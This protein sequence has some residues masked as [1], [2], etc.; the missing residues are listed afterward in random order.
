MQCVLNYLLLRNKCEF[1]FGLSV[2]DQKPCVGFRVATFQSHS[3]HGGSGA[4]TDG[5]GE[6]SMMRA[7]IGSVAD[8]P[9]V[10]NAMKC[11]AL[12]FNE[13]LSTTPLQCYNMR[14]H[15]GVWRN[16]TLRYSRRTKQMALMLCVQLEGV[17]DAIWQAELN[18]L[19]DVLRAV[20]RDEFT[21]VEGDGSKLIT[22][23][24][25]NSSIDGSNISHSSEGEALV[26][27]FCLQVKHTCMRF[28]PYI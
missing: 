27:G 14:T 11:I 16:L 5:G 7:E 6:P 8:C 15:V 21:D 12:V 26:T 20:R 10:P 24:E 23:I 19:S 22:G 1:T 28:L 25:S 4:Q 9:N 17:D 2:L 3:D 13:F 18:H